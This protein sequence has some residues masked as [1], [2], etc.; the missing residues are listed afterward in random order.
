MKKEEMT[1]MLTTKQETEAFQRNRMQ[2]DLAKCTDEQRELF[3]MI[4]PNGV[5]LNE[6]DDAW[7]LVKRTLVVNEKKAG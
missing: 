1:T 3:N 7:Q 5:P 4:W 6:L 2:E